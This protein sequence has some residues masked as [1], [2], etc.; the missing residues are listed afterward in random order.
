MRAEDIEALARPVRLALERNAQDRHHLEAILA[1]VL[2]LANEA[3]SL[4]AYPLTTPTMTMRAAVLDALQ[5]AGGEAITVAA[6]WRSAQVWGV[7]TQSRDSCRVI[8]STA[9]NLRLEG[10]PIERAGPRMWRWTADR[11][12]APDAGPQKG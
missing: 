4:S 11:R 2:A 12:P 8:D 5:Q 9:V 10:H 6:I 3:A 7:R 1:N